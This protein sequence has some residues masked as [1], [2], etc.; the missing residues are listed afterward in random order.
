MLTDTTVKIA[1]CDDLEEERQK[2]I[3]YLNK[4]VDIR[5]YVITIDEFIDGESLLSVDIEKY[6]LI[7][8][9]IF[10]NE[11]NGIEVAKEILNRSNHTPVIFCSTSNEFAEESYDVN[12]LRYLTKPIVEER[13]FNTLDKFF[14][15]QTALRMLT[16]KQNRMDES[17]YL[18]DILW[19]EAGDHKSVIHT[20]NG[21]ITTSTIF[22]QFQEE[23]KDA[24]FIKPIRFALVS[25]DAIASI[26]GED[27]KLIDGTVIGVSRDMRKD[28]KKAYTNYKM[29]KLL[30]KGGIL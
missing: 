1:V 13:F 12:A 10:M 24:D 17:V 3:E 15:T 16:F 21:D 30:K 14:N 11:L 5:E 19:I 18:A 26:P 4:Y 29:K 8:L 6:N 25:L 22:K 2:I 23:L 27:I 28:V 20:R 9:D 7:I